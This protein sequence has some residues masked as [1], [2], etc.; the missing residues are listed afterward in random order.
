MLLPNYSGKLFTT[1]K[2]GKAEASPG[3]LLFAAWN[4]IS[5]GLDVDGRSTRPTS[6]KD[7]TGLTRS[8]PSWA[9]T[10]TSCYT[11]SLI[12]AL[13]QSYPD[14]YFNLSKQS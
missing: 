2:R 5:I 6:Q 8:P 13:R 7:K 1:S 10:P 4:K 12:R 14:A 11:L 3:K 9:P